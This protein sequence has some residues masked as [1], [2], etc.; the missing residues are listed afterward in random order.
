MRPTKVKN[1]DYWCPVQTIYGHTENDHLDPQSDWLK[2]KMEL[3]NHK[4]ISY[5]KETVQKMKLMRESKK[6]RF[7]K[8]RR[9]TWRRKRMKQTP[10]ENPES[11]I[12]QNEWKFC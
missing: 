9:M 8:R 11:N 6:T 3:Y 1:G 5:K 10:R 4:H 12:Q 7:I 2:K